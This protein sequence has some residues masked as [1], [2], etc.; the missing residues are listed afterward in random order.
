MRWDLIARLQVIEGG[1]P[2]SEQS[3]PFPLV[4][5]LVLDQ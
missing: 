5:S 4:N 3:L 2:V 1:L